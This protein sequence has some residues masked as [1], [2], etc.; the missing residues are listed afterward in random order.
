M[1]AA[2]RQ[3]PPRA[4]ALAPQPG[5]RWEGL[6][7]RAEGPPWGHVGEGGGRAYLAEIDGKCRRAMPP[8]RCVNQMAHTGWRI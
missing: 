1:R 5:G 3:D 7:I 4:C 6:R 2:S 8:E